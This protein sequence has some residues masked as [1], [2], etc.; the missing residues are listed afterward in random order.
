M[1]ASDLQRYCQD[2]DG[3]TFFGDLGWMDGAVPV[4]VVDYAARERNSYT[5]L[6]GVALPASVSR[7]DVSW[8]GADEPSLSV[9]V[10]RG[11]LGGVEAVQPRGRYLDD[12][13][14]RFYDRSDCTLVPV[15]LDWKG[16]EREVACLVDH[17]T[18]DSHSYDVLELV[19][20][21]ESEVSRLDCED[22]AGP[23]FRVSVDQRLE[24]RF[25]R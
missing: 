13:L 3:E 15:E 23:Y 5:D 1:D 21:G 6:W 17:S 19:F 24:R 10:L 2:A 22:G 14:E 18:A 16:T 7:G 12:Q 25:Q 9:E 4:C 20:P 11:D 8:K